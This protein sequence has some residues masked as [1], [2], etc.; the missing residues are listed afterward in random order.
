[1]VALGAPG[2]AAVVES[3]GIFGAELDRLGV[4]LDGFV[5]LVLVVMEDAAVVVGDREIVAGPTAGRD[6]PGA[7]GDPLVDRGI[8]A[9]AEPLILLERR[10][11]DARRGRRQ[12]FC[13]NAE[14]QQPVAGCVVRPFAV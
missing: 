14:R 13:R 11:A 1:E 10:R 7:G 3:A 6:L 8:A 5:E 12:R 2:I 9:V 4:V